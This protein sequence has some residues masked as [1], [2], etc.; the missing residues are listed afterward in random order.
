MR[1][2]PAR[3]AAPEPDSW[4][5]I[6]SLE[7]LPELEELLD[8]RFLVDSGQSRAVRM[9]SDGKGYV[10]VDSDIEAAIELERAE[11]RHLSHRRWRS[12][13]RTLRLQRR[14]KIQKM[15]MGLSTLLI[16]AI[17]SVIAVKYFK[18]LPAQAASGNVSRSFIPVM[19]PLVVEGKQV[20]VLSVASSAKEFEKQNGLTGLSPMQDSFRKETYSSRRSAPALEYRNV[21]DIVLN[22]NSSQQKITTTDLTVGEILTNNGIV[23]DSDDIVSPSR[24]TPALGVQSISV[25]RVSTATRTAEQ[26]IA[27]KTEKQNDSSLLKGKTSIKRAGVSGKET[28]IYTQTL[29]DGQVVSEAIT[30]RVVTKAP[31]SQIVVVGTKNP[32]TQGGK[33]TYYSAPGGTCAHRTL[34]M[35]TMVTVTNTS[36]GASTVCRVAD[37]GPFGAGRVIDLSRDGFSKI[38][39]LSQGVASVTLSW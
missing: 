4:I 25:T 16:L 32:Q 26:T 33:A 23:L 9:G 7:A 36:T 14:A 21:K 30:S 18:P 27:F 5:P 1:P 39:P 24:E 20:S 38:A 29:K 8:P 2:S 11:K 28:L 17:V 34:P 13:R 22:V 19:V 3:K 37:R 6:E 31:I 15:I 12:K 10:L 35:G